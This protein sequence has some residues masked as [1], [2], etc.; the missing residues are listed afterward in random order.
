MQGMAD[1]SPSPPKVLLAGG[2]LAN[3]LIAYR[4]KQ[5][6]PEV[7]V[8]LIEAE[9][10]LGGRHT[11][12]FFASDPAG[13]AGWLA[14]F[15]V[16]TWDRYEVR[17]PRRR[18]V[19]ETAYCSITS[20]RLHEVVTEALKA[21][22]ILS[23]PIKSLSAEEVVLHDGRRL[24]GDV[25]VDGRGPGSFD[26]LDLGYQKFLGLTVR[27]AEDHA[28][29]GPTVMDACVEQS[30]GYRF[31]YVLPWD[32]RRLL[33]EDTY[34]SDTRHLDR[35]AARANLMAYAHAQGWTVEQ[36]LEEEEGVLPVA[37][38]GDIEAHWSQG[39]GLPLSGLRAALFHP[40]TGYSLSEA[41]L[42]ADAFCRLPTFDAV[43]VSAFSRAWST[44][45]WRRGGF[46][47]LLNRM[48]FRADAPDRRYLIFQ[49]FYGLSEPLIRRFYAA[50]MTRGDKVRVLTGKPPVPIRRALGCL[51]E[52]HSS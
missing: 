18:R 17:F 45:R 13:V 52:R 3:S 16:Q 36:V 19:L 38:G 41:V 1:L 48:L 10:R 39:G 33:I 34:Y 4:L 50:E 20:E 30:D 22:V 7:E 46:F 12:S 49:R 42:L 9:D 44:E 11:W 26:R 24:C 35:N 28:L 51:Q 27:L 23:A 32:R 47:R 8:Q 40:T 14:P 29:D 31:V 37:M 15:V 5:I 6:R 43:S 25:V 2:G 21:G